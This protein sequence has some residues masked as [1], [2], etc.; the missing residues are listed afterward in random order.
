MKKQVGVALCLAWAA[1]CCLAGSSQA[2]K[3]KYEKLGT[4]GGNQNYTGFTY[5]DA[6]IN[7]AGQVVGYS[8]TAAG[9]KHAFVKFPGKAMQ[10]LGL[11]PGSNESRAPGINNSGVIGGYF[12]DSTGNHA[13]RWVPSGGQYQLQSL[14]GTKSM[15][16]GINDDGY[17]VGAAN[18]A[19]GQHAQVK[20]PGGTAQDLGTMPGHVASM[21]TGINNSRSI[22]GLSYDGSKDTACIWSPS[23]ASYTVAASL[24]G[25]ADSRALAINN[26][27]QAVGYRRVSANLHALLKSPGQALQDL[28]NLGGN[29]SIAWDINDSGWVVGLS[30]TGHGTTAFLWT[31]TGGMQDLNTLVV[32]LPPGVWLCY[33]MAI[34]KHGEIA[35]YTLNSVYKLTPIADPPF[36]LLMGD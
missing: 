20:P 34:N 23:G 11:I 4:L 3:F 17:V 1:V 10:D 27:G 33:A 9:Q 35:G 31:P 22:V 32:N 21:A 14:G 26:P 16:L 5:K 8:Y 24:F 15:V 2:I 12:H 30:E 36:S 29:P 13:C 19:T 18:T 25:V 28:G 6:G 7:D